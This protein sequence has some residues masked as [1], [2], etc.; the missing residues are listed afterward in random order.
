MIFLRD[1]TI[2]DAPLV[3]AWHSNPMIQSGFY[4]LGNE[5]RPLSWE[6]HHR[7]WTLTTKYWKKLMVVLV[8]NDIERPIGIVRISPLED[9]SPQL[10]FTIGEI[11]LWGKG[12]GKEVVRLALEWLKEHGYKHTHTSVRKSN[13]RA[14]GLLLSL[15]YVIIGEARK[16]EVWLQKKL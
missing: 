5:P 2:N 13:K 12:Y 4:T 14:L 15:G 8:E 11:S 7:W 16:E 1:T 3:M 10:S 6:E 9:F